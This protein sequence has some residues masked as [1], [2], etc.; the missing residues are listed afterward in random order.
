M[1]YIYKITN[2]IN[3]KIYIGLTRETIEERWKSHI[4]KAKQYPNRYLYNAMNCYGYENFVIEPIEECSNDI[5]DEREI[6]WISYFNST[7]PDIGYNLTEGGGGGNT[8]A[9]NPHK[10]ETGEKIRQQKLKDKYVPITK[11]AFEEDAKNKLT[12][13]EMCQKYHCSHETLRHRCQDFFGCFISELRTVENSGQFTKIN[14]NKEDLYQDIIKCK[15][16]NQQIAT[17]YGVS[18]HTI[19]NRCKEYFGKTPNE[20]RGNQSAKRS[21]IDDEE[22]L[23]K[24]IL[25]GKTLQ[26]IASA[27]QMSKNTLVT[28]IK[29]KYQMNFKEYRKYVK[30]KN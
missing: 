20:L 5:L 2:Q 22:L 3:Q 7:N 12:V 1:G 15:L 6:Y 24:L 13:E 28:R 16:S 17:K 18:D 23:N 9:L 29:E 10:L 25:E 21:S 30:S 8:W 27:F 4:K 14:I 11:E 26:E 19:I